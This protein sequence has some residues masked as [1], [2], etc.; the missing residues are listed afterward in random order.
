MTE[1]NYFALFGNREASAGILYHL[2]TAARIHTAKT[3]ES[4]G[5]Q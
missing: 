3:K 4:R 5:P 2:G 1:G